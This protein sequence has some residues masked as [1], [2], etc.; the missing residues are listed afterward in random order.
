MD[1][2]VQ[3]LYCLHR[4]H[5][6][7]QLVLVVLSVQLVLLPYYQHLL[8]LVVLSVLSVLSVQLLC[9]QLLWHLLTLVIPVDLVG[10]LDQQLYYRLRLAL[11]VP[12]APV[13]L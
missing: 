10:L 2:L 8:A 5:R 13:G 6:L 1:P 11:V 9:C 3:L 12:Q 4:Q 7:H